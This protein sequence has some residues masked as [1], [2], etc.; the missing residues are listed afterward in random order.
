LHDFQAKPVIV[1]V[2]KKGSRSK[3]TKS[4]R[5]KE[6]EPPSLEHKNCKKK[7]RKTINITLNE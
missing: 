3:A 5:R 4:F 1:G 6:E 2:D 7:S